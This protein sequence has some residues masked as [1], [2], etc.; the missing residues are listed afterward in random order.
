RLIVRNGI[1]EWLG[2]CPVPADADA[3][4]LV[5]PSKL[6]YRPRRLPVVVDYPQLREPILWSDHILRQT[7]CHASSPLCS[8]HEC[9]AADLLGSSID[10]ATTSSIDQSRL[11][12]PAAI[13]GEVR[14]VLWMRTNL[15]QSAYSVTMYS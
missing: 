8:T 9:L 11:S 12:I 10:S 3:A 7:V 14:S 4:R 1:P 2:R 5:V 15:Y 13:A 6:G